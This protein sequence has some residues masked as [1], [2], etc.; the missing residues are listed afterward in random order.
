MP[1]KN[2]LS[3]ALD[4]FESCGELKGSQPPPYPPLL[5]S[6]KVAQLFARSNALQQSLECLPHRERWVVESG[7]DENNEARMCD[8]ALRMPT[9]QAPLKNVLCLLSFHRARNIT[10]NSLFVK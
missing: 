3:I 7:W 1:Q 2:L 8:V 5:S 10:E 6:E 9:I 4:L